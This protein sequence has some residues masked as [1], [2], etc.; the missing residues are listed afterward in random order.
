[1]F[2]LDFLLLAIL[3][4][5]IIVILRKK[6]SALRGLKE[7]K[8]SWQLK[9]INHYRKRQGLKSLHTYY[10]LDRIAKGHSRYLAQYHACNHDGFSQRAQWVKHISGGGYIGENCYQYPARG[11]NRR[12]AVKLVQGWMKS[13]GHRANL[14]NPNFTKL[15]IGIVKRGNYIYA[16]QI[17]SS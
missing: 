15:G 3:V 11:Y 10:A 13:P 9:I 2:L 8:G 5:G 12:V 4:V 14:M 6:Y 7:R 1:M 17:F 16:T